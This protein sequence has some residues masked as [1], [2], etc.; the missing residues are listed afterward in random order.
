MYLL[1]NVAN[2]KWA[3]GMMQP[4]RLSNIK[5]PFIFLG[6]EGNEVGKIKEDFDWFMYCVKC[7]FYNMC[8]LGKV[9][10]NHSSLS[11]RKWWFIIVIFIKF[12][13]LTYKGVK[14]EVGFWFSG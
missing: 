3:L 11:P 10:R 13:F 4:R 7:I 14:C 12:I 1:I 9:G 8:V 6:L 2:L 5:Q